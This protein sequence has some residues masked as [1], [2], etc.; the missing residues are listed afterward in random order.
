MTAAALL[1]LCW[2]LLKRCLLLPAAHLLTDAGEKKLLA[3]LEADVL[4]CEV[5]Q[6]CCSLLN[7]LLQFPHEP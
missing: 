2:S 4:C 3:L 7:P 1:L 6:L 5:V